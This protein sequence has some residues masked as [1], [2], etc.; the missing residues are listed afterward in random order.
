MFR[1]R[2]RPP[3]ACARRRNATAPCSARRWRWR[4]S[5]FSFLA[6][7]ASRSNVVAIPRRVEAGAEMRLQHA[8]LQAVRAAAPRSN[9]VM[10]APSSA[11]SRRI[12]A[13]AP[14][15]RACCIRRVA[16]SMRRVAID[17]RGAQRAV[18][19]RAHQRGQGDLAGAPQRD[20]RHQPDQPRRA[21]GEASLRALAPRRRCGRA[22]T[23][24]P[25]VPSRADNSR[26]ARSRARPVRATGHVNGRKRRQ[27]SPSR[28]AAIDRLLCGI[29]YRRATDRRCIGNLD[30]FL[31]PRSRGSASACGAALPPRRRM[32]AQ[33]RKRPLAPECNLAVMLTAVEVLE[34]HWSSLPRRVGRNCCGHPRRIWSFPDLASNALYTSLFAISLIGG[35]P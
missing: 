27:S 19:M 35:D 16:A 8:R 28:E 25:R 22:R 12:S 31:F 15:S 24:S 34:P 29:L 17:Q 14:A 32:L 10:A 4:R 11:T 30:H 9:V 5:S 20:H 13:C 21:S 26:S 6:P 33:E 2:P 18:G 3:R 1:A 7:S 23:R